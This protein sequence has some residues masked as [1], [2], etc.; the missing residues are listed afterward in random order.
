VTNLVFVADSY[1]CVKIKAHPGEPARMGFLLRSRVALA[2]GWCRRSDKT[3]F[4]AKSFHP[5]A[6]FAPRHDSSW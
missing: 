4:R 6:G 5:L 3:L 1:Q 2:L